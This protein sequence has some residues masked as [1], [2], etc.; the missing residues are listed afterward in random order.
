MLKRLVLIAITLFWLVMN[1]L[2]WQ[3]DFRA[4]DI[5]GGKVP[6]N[7]V[8]DKMLRSADDSFLYLFK[9]KERVGDLRWSTDVVDFMTQS[10]TEENE[11]SQF[12]EAEEKDLVFMTD[13]MVMSPGNY[14]VEIR[15]GRIYL[16]KEFGQVQFEVLAN[17]STNNSWN[18]FDI[19]LRQK[20]K[21]L[22]LLANSTNETLSITFDQG[23]E[24]S[25][26]FHREL[27]SEQMKDPQQIIAA[28]VGT[29]PIAAF[30]GGLLAGLETPANPQFSPGQ[31]LK[32]GLRWEARQDWL[33]VGHSRLRCY[34][35]TL[36]LPEDKNISIYISRAG[37]VM[38]ILLPGGYEMRNARLLLL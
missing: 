34:R 2:L 22:K 35:I 38:R 25:P 24:N 36:F 5:A 8:W 21:R 33:H 31:L 7:L 20:R 17:F 28:L 6:I 13:G 37:E 10:A 11:E 12:D 32:L 23:E 18:S 14:N 9:G 30:A 19:S 3:K 4:A 15:A 27:T 26:V 29:A 1:Y 16:G